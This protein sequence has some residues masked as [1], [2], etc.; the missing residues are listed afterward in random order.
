MGP[1]RSANSTLYIYYAKNIAASAAGNEITVTLSGAVP[2]PWIDIAEYSGISSSTPVDTTASGNSG[3]GTGTALTTG[4]LVTNN[5]CDL[6]IAS[7]F[8][9]Q[10]VTAL[11]TNF[12]MRSNSWG[13]V[14]EERIVS[15]TGTYTAT[16]TQSPAAEWSAGAVAFKKDLGVQA[17]NPIRSVQWTGTVTDTASQLSTMTVPFM[18]A[19]TAG[20]MNV[21]VATWEGTTGTVS[22]ISDTR[23][24]TYT[25]AS[26]PIRSTG[27]TQ[28]VYYAKNIAAGTNTITVN[29]STTLAMQLTAIEYAGL[30]TTSPFDQVASATGS[31]TAPDS[32]S[33][34]TNYAN[35]LILGIFK[36]PYSA[37]YQ[38]VK[39]ASGFSPVAFDVRVPASFV[40]EKIVSSTGTYNATATYNNSLTWIAHVVTFH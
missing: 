36:V 35:E 38:R 3:A 9:G 1:V 11:G 17:L 19:Q 13:N 28:Y 27:A 37:S 10:Y 20:N 16:W 25:L 8:V 31:G 21:L 26:G 14:T 39:S 29:V 15:S 30:S 40:Q 4:N 6:I 32:G 23:G 22:S 2:G 24:N 12:K 5:A 33:V 34:T 18:Q 7:S